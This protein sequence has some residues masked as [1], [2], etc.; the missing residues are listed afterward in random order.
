MPSIF[1]DTR[2]A[3]RLVARTLLSLALLAGLGA[4]GDEDEPLTGSW[5]G[6][7]TQEPQERSGTM[8]LSLSQAGTSLDGRWEAEFPPAD[9][10][11]G[12]IE[13]TVSDA[14]VRAR[15]LPDSP[16]VCPYDWTATS[17]AERISGRY[18]AFDC[19][20]EIVGEIDVLRE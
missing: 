17:G 1:L 18:A 4:C 3:R 20:V 9:P 14:T 5:I 2:V 12:T 10:Y 6:T 8:R 13:G 16:E 11:G 19:R 15:L 7:F